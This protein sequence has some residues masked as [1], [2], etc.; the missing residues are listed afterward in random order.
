M[1]L[2]SVAGG[3]ICGRTG[4]ALFTDRLE[5]GVDRCLKEVALL[6]RVGLGDLCGGVGGVSGGLIGT[7]PA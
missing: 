4:P 6:A 2:I 7:D 1:A 5:A 3:V